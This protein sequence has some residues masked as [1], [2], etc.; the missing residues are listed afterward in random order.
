MVLVNREKQAPSG[1][2]ST[3]HIQCQL[4]RNFL[5]C[6]PIFLISFLDFILQN[7]ATTSNGYKTFLQLIQKLSVVQF[8]F[9]LKN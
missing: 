6:L 9:S 8:L 2:V 1:F 4:R 7:R 5:D 3:L